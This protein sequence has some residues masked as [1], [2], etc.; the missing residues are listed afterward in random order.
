LGLFST[1][2]RQK[3]AAEAAQFGTPMALSRSFG[4]CF[5]L[6]YRLKSFGGTTRKV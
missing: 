6:Q 2:G 5:C 4:D 1:D 3:D